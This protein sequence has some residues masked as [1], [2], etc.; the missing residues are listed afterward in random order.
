MAYDICFDKA[1]MQKVKTQRRVV[2]IYMYNSHPSLGSF[3][4]KPSFYLTDRGQITVQAG[5]QAGSAECRGCVSAPRVFGISMNG[6]IRLDGYRRREHVRLAAG[7]DNSVRTSAQGRGGLLRRVVEVS[8]I[9]VPR[10]AG[11]SSQQSDITW[12]LRTPNCM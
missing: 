6:Q 9:R 4:V 10:L 1:R 7:T 8:F 5:Q 12:T 11:Q 3:K 2:D